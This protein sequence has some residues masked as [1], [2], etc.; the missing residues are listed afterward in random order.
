MPWGDLMAQPGSQTHGN[1]SGHPA[2]DYVEHERTYNGFLV[3]TKWGTISVA[4]ILVLMAIFL[5]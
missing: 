1:G 3:L 4:L 2:M 5:L